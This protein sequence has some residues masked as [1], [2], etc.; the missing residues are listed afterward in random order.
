MRNITDLR[1]KP[2]DIDYFGACPV[3]HR[4]G[5]HAN[6]GREDW[7]DVQFRREV[8]RLARS[9]DGAGWHRL[10]APEYGPWKAY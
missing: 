7:F 6:V 1:P 5:V 3:C 2:E 9:P 10:M 8:L 4:S